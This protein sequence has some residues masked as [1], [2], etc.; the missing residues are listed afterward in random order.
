MATAPAGSLTC[1]QFTDYLI[2]KSE[3]LDEIIIR[4][5]TPTSGWPGHVETGTFEAY[6]GVS[7]TFDKV[8][9]VFPDLSGCWTTRT[10][11]SC[12]G[13]PCDY[14]EKRIGFGST[15]DSYS[16]QYANYGS[17]LFCFDQI[18]SADKA[19]EQ[20]SMIIGNLKDA[21]MIIS[22][23]RLRSEAFRIA[24]TK[25]AAGVGM[26]EFTYTTN[27]DCTR[28]VPSVLPTSK[29]TIQMLQR[30]LEPLT[31]NG[32]FGK[33]PAGIPIAEVVT[34]KITSYNLVQGNTALASLF[35]FEDFTVGGNLYKYGMTSGIGNFGF[36]IDEHPMRFQ[37]LADGVTLERVF[38][39]VNVDATQ[40]IKGIVND[41][42]V[43]ARYQIDFIWHKMAMKSL[44]RD[45]KP[46]NPMMPFAARD[47][48]GK[49]QFVM[50][51][52][53]ADANGCVINN[54]R[55]N[56]GKFIAD[57]ENAT[58]A[59]YPEFA[60]AFLSLREPACVTD[61]TPC[62]EDP[63]YVEQDYNS[64]N[65]LC[66]NPDLT[67]DLSG[68]TAPFS[69]EANTITCNGVPIDHAASGS[70]AD[71]AAVVTWL[72]ANVSELGDFTQDGD[73]IVLSNSTCNTVDLAIQGS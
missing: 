55:R 8:N 16:L 70:L 29:L 59:Q 66:P 33:T 46:V 64:A 50:D 34:D 5:I 39:Y 11:G 15:R 23:E 30:Q 65:D 6:D 28:I 61:V 3:H 47:F 62:T 43:N 37:L 7:H 40:G 4:D 9:R 42:Y 21:S 69:I 38:P 57:F 44:V 52:L 14:T 13:T 26:Q 18:L 31:L 10:A 68:L 51:N 56:K 71:V 35:R 45:A 49:W 73:N 60:I 41:A 67:F 63:G 24:G 12:I 20:F 36:R 2:R 22:S 32:Y 27:E 53:G 48:A 25:I 72:E 58:K 17:D 1:K 19:K 54:E